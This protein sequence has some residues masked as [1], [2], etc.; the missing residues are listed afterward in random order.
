M[1]NNFCLFS[2]DPETVIVPILCSIVVF[3]I[4]VAALICLLRHYNRRARAKDKFRYS[5]T[6]ENCF[7]SLFD[8]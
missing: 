8:Y 6:H 5:Q 7:I 3:P 2:V 4:V 1:H